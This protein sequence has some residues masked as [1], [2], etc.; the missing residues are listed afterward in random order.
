LDICTSFL[1]LYQKTYNIFPFK[2]KGAAADNVTL[3]KVLIQGGICDAEEQCGP[4]IV[5]LGEPRYYGRPGDKQ[6]S[7]YGILSSYPE[8]YLMAF[9]LHLPPAQ[10]PET[11]FYSKEFHAL[12]AQKEIPMNPVYGILRYDLNSVQP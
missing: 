2:K 5:V 11:A 3:P 9:T 1:Y 8:E 6:A 10:F 7:V 4:F 12:Q